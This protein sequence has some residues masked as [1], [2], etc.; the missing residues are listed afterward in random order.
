MSS[1]IEKK[2]LER[3]IKL[4]A[5]PSRPPQLPNLERAAELLEELPT[6]WL[7]EGVTDEQREALLQ[8]VFHGITIDG[9]EF[10]SIEPNPAYVPLFATIVADQKLGHRAVE[11][12]PPPPSHDSDA[13]AF[14]LGR[15]CA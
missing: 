11:C 10:A 13:P 2:G 12:I 1:P 6:L 7:H 4:A 5:P 15:F 8:E 9:K 3:Q 14:R